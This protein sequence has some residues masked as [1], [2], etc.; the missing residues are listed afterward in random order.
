MSKPDANSDSPQ[1]GDI[2]TDRWWP[3]WGNGIVTV[4]K[5][6]RLTVLFS[7]G[8]KKYDAAHFQFLD[9]VRTQAQRMGVLRAA[10]EELGRKLAE[11]KRGAA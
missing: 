9:V 6:S 7:G 1:K 3:E 10:H 8:A 5:K 11:G 2:V 4:R